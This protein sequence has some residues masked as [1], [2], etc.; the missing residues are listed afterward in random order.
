M[1]SDSLAGFTHSLHVLPCFAD[2]RSL[3]IR[4]YLGY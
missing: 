4:K 2:T 1:G 3:W